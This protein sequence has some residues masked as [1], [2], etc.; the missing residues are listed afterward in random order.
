MAIKNGLYVKMKQAEFLRV[1]IGLRARRL[2][3]LGG[4]ITGQASGNEICPEEMAGC[5]GLAF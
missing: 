4:R 2:R 5:R 1:E 3:H